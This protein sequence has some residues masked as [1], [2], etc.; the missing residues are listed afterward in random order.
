M[1]YTIVLQ[2]I[3]TLTLSTG[4]DVKVDMIMIRRSTFVGD[5]WAYGSMKGQVIYTSVMHIW[6]SSSLA[7]MVAYPLSLQLKLKA[8]LLGLQMG[9][10]LINRVERY[11]LATAA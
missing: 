6:A 3:K 4:K 9:W 10:I 11:I 8:F 7:L 1:S 5:H 2:L